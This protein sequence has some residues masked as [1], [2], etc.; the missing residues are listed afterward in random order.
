MKMPSCSDY[1]EALKGCMMGERKSGVRQRKKRIV[2]FLLYLSLIGFLTT[3]CASLLP[4]FQDR[5]MQIVS[6]QAVPYNLKIIP[7]KTTKGE[8]LSSSGSPTGVWKEK[9]VL[10]YF[11][12]ESEKDLFAEAFFP[13][14]CKKNNIFGFKWETCESHERNYYNKMCFLLFDQNDVLKNYSVQGRPNNIDEVGANLEAWPVNV[15]GQRQ[16]T[17]DATLSGSIMILRIITTNDGIQNKSKES[18]C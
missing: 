8:I 13:K 15:T 7:G 4:L 16:Q 11:W 5:D 18:Q 14:K 17:S 1:W 12:Q 6:G 2:G 10:T 9:N 3:G